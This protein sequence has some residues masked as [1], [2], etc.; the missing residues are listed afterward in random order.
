MNYLD[1]LKLIES[2]K[3]IIGKEYNGFY[4]SG[5]LIVPSSYWKR[6]KFLKLYYDTKNAFMSIQP[7]KT[8]DLLVWA[9]DFRKLSEG[10]IDYIKVL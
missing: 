5:F 10:K 4:V 1:A 9:V 8:E 3:S 6:R 2:R 7:Y